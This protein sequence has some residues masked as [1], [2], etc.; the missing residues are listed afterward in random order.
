MGT[1]VLNFFP[2]KLVKVLLLGQSICELCKRNNQKDVF[3][4]F[5]KNIQR[6]FK[7]SNL[8]NIFKAFILTLNYPEYSRIVFIF[9][10][11]VFNYVIGIKFANI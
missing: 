4:S 5:F 2:A 7:G 8:V 3:F 9:L 10:Q 6:G 11:F 1:I